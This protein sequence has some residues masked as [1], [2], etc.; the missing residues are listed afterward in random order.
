MESFE[1]FWTLYPRRVGKKDARLAWSRLTSEQ[2]FAAVTS[3]PLHVRYWNAAGTTPEFTPYPATWLRG[4]RWE[5]ELAMPEAPQ[6]AWWKSTE[7]IEAKARELR[8]TARPGEGY[9]ELKARILAA[10]RAA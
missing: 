6:S 5:D 1:K 3:L 9:H 8:I 7:G 2:Q 10:E 4:E